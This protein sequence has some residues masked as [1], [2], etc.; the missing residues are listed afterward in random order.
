MSGV[1]QVKPVMMFSLL[2][3]V[4]ISSMLVGTNIFQSEGEQA[5]TYIFPMEDWVKNDDVNTIRLINVLLEEEVPVYW[6]LDQFTVDG[7]TYPA[8]TFYVKTPF[9]TRQG[10]SSEVTMS[11][12]MLQSK[13]NR[14]WRID[15]AN[16]T[17]TVNSKQLV[18]P[19]IVLFYDTTTYENALMHYL[20][21]RSLGFKTVLA[22]AI[23]IYSKAWNESGSVLNEANVFVMPGGAVHFWSFPWGDPL[24]WGLGN[25]TEFVKSGGGYIGVCAGT[26]EALS[27]T[28]YG[29]LQF[30]NATMYDGVRQDMY[31]RDWKILQGPLYINVEQ[32]NNPVMFGY[33]PEAVRPGYG[34]QTTIYYLGGPA[35]HDVG[36]NAT[37]LATYAAPVTQEAMSSVSNQWG[38]AAVIGADYY[39]GKI[40]LF[41]PHPEYPGPCARLYAQALYYVANVPKTSRL[42]PKIMEPMSDAAISE[43]V[44]AIRSAVDQIK[45]VLEETTRTA[46]KIV[47]LRTG[48]IYHPLGIAV[49]VH[50]VSFSKELYSELNE[51]QR[52]ALKFQYEYAKLDALRGM[53]QNDPQLL[54]LIDYAQAMISSY[55]DLSANFPKDEHVIFDT[56]WT[57]IGPFPPFTDDA[58]SFEGLVNA[59]KYVNNETSAV[60]YPTA[61]NYSKVFREYDRLKVQNDTAYTP[62]LNAT[63]SALFQNITAQ[64]PAGIFMRAY[65]TFFHTLDIVQYKI[66]YNIFNLL[67]LGDRTSEVIAYLEYALSTAVGTLNYASAEMQ[68]FIAHPEG[69]FL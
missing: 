48:D 35:M 38:A 34:P 45:P 37:V 5:K 9:T 25:I 14:V 42:E 52:Y 1:K 66:A 65:Y 15:T 44:G 69:P 64:W 31:A 7:N 17:P 6:A 62:E 57:G 18:L 50:M 51:V 55:Y 26:V 8:G 10:V 53:V 2:A 29:E 56:H 54:G 27:T 13:L 58:T 19:R 20:R 3:T 67:T 4:L 36:A 60:L 40:V 30:V 68:A 39:D 23:D 46:A 49:D 41:G 16:Q 59:F 47:N 21:F 33:G 61:L 12:L 22:N 24:A 28:G 11:W 43:R 63:L 32:P